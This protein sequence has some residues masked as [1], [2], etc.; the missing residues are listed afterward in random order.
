ME[1]QKDP[2]HVYRIM[3]HFVWIPKYR[4][5][6]FK[7]PYRE[8]LKAIIRKIAYDYEM[9]VFE[10]EIV[11]D[12]IHMLVGARPSKSPSKIIQIIKSVSAREFF[13]LYPEIKKKYFW[14][15]K[16]GIRVKNALSVLNE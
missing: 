3:Y 9:E 10:I 7:D 1:L 2:H 15:G 14:G 11:I 4:N 16:K 13:N 8:K 12:H 5:K 6:V